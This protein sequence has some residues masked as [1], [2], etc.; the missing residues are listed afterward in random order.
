MWQLCYPVAAMISGPV[1][2]YILDLTSWRWLLIIEGIFPIVWLA[3]WHFGTAN[4]PREAKWLTTEDCDAVIAHVE[5]GRPAAIRTEPFGS[6]KFRAQLKRPVIVFFTLAAILWNVGFLAIVVWLPS[7]LAEHKQLSQVGVGWL[8]AIPYAIAIIA[9]VTMTRFADRTGKRWQICVG[10]LVM[11]GAALIIGSVVAPNSLPVTIVSVSIAAMGVYGGWP[12]YWSI[13]PSILPPSVHG[14]VLGAVN[15]IAVLGAF[16]GPYVV[17][18][19]RDLTDT[20][21]AGMITVAC[22]LFGAALCV[23][24]ARID[25]A[26]AAQIAHEPA[27]A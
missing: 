4:S 8:T 2:G 7:A 11:A 12:V 27:P 6:A 19:V 22:C 3:A 14:A 24:L 18:W 26:T 20:F 5:A 25:K 21:S 10:G 17:G 15:G 13:P 9:L 23:F 1:A 16:G